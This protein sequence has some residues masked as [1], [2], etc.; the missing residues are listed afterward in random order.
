MKSKTTT[1][2]GILLGLV[3]VVFS[4]NGFLHFFPDQ[5]MGEQAGRFMG[6][7]GASGYFFP[8]LMA[9]QLVA[10]ALLLI[11][12]FVPLALAMLAPVVVNIV[13]F[14]LFLAPAGF[15][16]AALILG[17]EIFL[18][19]SYRGAFRPLFRARAE[20]A[21]ASEPASVGAGRASAR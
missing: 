15:P 12:R 3:F 7:L 6:G 16:V 10:G 2:A 1:T 14:H 17:L 18:L 13:G 11:R 4:L 8:L 19:W 5:P 20:V 21:P 9:T